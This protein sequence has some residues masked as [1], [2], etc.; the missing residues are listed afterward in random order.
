MYVVEVDALLQG[1]VDDVYMIAGHTHPHTHGTCNVYVNV[2][3]DTLELWN[4]PTTLEQPQ[5][6]LSW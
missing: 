3:V 5:S 4:T 6:L 1:V 2:R